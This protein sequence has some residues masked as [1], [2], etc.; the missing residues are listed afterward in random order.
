MN[1]RKKTYIKWIKRILIIGVVFAA[2]C[3]TFIMLY[4]V[5]ETADY[6]EP[7]LIVL[8][9]RVVGDE[10][11]AVLK[12]RLDA[13]VKYYEK[14]QNC[15]IIVSGGQGKDEIV[16]EALVM[17]AY[18]AANGVP[19]EKIIMENRSSS[20]YENMLYSAP[21]A[22]PFSPDAKVAVVTSEFHI[23]R[24]VRFARAAG[25]DASH[26]Y[27]GTPFYALPYYLPR[28][29]MAIIKMWIIGK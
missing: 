29:C 22:L 17:Q 10:P 11:S 5:N 13:A 23:F 9:A 1:Q 24:A 15:I 27:A 21:L 8:G 19:K 18:L 25:L 4:G 20:T 2:A 6:N 12:T 7:V 3:F 16:P 26:V 28:E 14:N